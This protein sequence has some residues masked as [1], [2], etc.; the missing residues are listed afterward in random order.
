M[1]LSPLYTYVQELIT[2]NRDFTLTL[3]SGDKIDALVGQAQFST[4]GALSV[5]SGNVTQVINE[6]TIVQIRHR[7]SA[8]T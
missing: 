2:A 5:T 8:M 1:T 3:N 6:S 4:A 7:G